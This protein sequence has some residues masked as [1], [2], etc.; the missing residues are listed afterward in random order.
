M[1]PAC[2]WLAC[3]NERRAGRAAIG[4]FNGDGYADILW[5]SDNGQV[6]IWEM[7]GTSFIGGASL[8]NPG[9]GWHPIAK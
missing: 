9:P 6:A 5:Q 7:N 4:D 2:A 1:S 3:R 8:G